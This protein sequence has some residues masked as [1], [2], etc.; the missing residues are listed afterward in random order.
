MQPDK[1]QTKRAKAS[2]SVGEVVVH[3]RIMVLQHCLWMLLLLSTWSPTAHAEYSSPPEVVIPLRVTDTT[4]HISPDWLSYIAC[5]LEEGDILSPWNTR[6]T[7][8]QETSYWSPT[9]T[10]ET[11]LQNNLLCEVTATTMAIYVEIQT[12]LSLLIPVLGV[13][14]AY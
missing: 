10:K 7:L 8:Y 9:V 3:E 14:K 2:L 13:C 11:S 4:R 12:P 1:V 6:N 5:A